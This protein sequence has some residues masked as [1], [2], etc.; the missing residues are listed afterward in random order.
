M[1]NNCLEQVPITIGD[2]INLKRLDLSNN[3]IEILP[4]TLGDLHETLDVLYIENNPLIIPPRTI[5]QKG[6]EV[7]LQYIKS[8]Q[9][10]SKILIAKSVLM[11]N[12]MKFINNPT[13][14]DVIFKLNS[15]GND[16]ICYG[17][18]IF[19][20]RYNKLK[21]LVSTSTFEE[22]EKTVVS[23]DN[24]TKE[25]FVILLEYIYTGEINVIEWSMREDILIA[26]QT[27]QSNFLNFSR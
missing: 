21:M 25:V 8:M 1:Q 26:A 12:I 17:H 6:S 7:V 14:A 18:K 4:T 24:I 2:L 13:F 19:L 23:L 22:N 3:Q 20:Y 11:T 10:G 16:S 9:V 5:I 27:L 15:E